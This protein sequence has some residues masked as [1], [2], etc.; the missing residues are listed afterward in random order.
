MKTKIK[1]LL[2][3]YF[4]HELASATII[5]STTMQIKTILICFLKMNEVLT[6]LEWHEGK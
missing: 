5:E 6:G 4:P 2:N 3:N 1:I